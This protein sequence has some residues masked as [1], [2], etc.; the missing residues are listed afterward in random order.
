MWQK[1]S[2]YWRT[3]GKQVFECGNVRAQSAGNYSPPRSSAWKRISKKKAGSCSPL[4]VMGS[5]DERAPHTPGHMHL[6]VAPQASWT[7]AQNSE[8]HCSGLF[9]EGAGRAD[10]FWTPFRSW[11]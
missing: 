6:V 4:G 9:Q 5:C 10:H 11:R 2:S 1:L 8:T 7:S 3:V